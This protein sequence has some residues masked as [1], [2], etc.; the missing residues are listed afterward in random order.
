MSTFPALL[1]VALGFVCLADAHVFTEEE[2]EFFKQLTFDQLPQELKVA[3]RK[4]TRHGVSSWCCTNDKPIKSIQH[5]KVVSETVKVTSR[6]KVGYTKCGFLA[7]N[8]CATYDVRY[9]NQLKYAV[10]YYEVPDKSQCAE[11]DIKC[12]EHDLQIAGN[13]LELSEANKYVDTLTKLKDNG[14]L[15]LLG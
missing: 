8:M 3:L 13:C 6:V 1:L 14:L 10:T 5:S 7:T 11:K 12:C 15:D 2:R 4:R 9:Q